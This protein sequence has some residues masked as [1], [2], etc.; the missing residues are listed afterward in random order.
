MPKSERQKLKLLYLRDYLC[1]NTDE[2]H[3]ASVQKLIDYLAAQDI[4]AERKSIYDDIRNLNDYGIEVLH[5][6]GRNGGYYVAQRDFELHELKLL[7]DAV[8]S[9]RFLSSK[10][11][12]LLI[13]K[14][15]A[16]SSSH[17]S[18][19]LRRELVL[20]GRLKT[21]NDD[22]F[23]SVDLLHDAIGRDSQIT[24]RY[25]DWGVDLQKHFRDK[26]YTASP[27]ALLWDDENYYLIAHSEKHGLTHFRVDKMEQICLTGKHR[28]FTDESRQFDPASYSK[29]VFGMY[30]GERSRVKL[31]FEN[32]LAG[33]VVDRFGRDIMLIPDGKDYFTMTTTVSISP[34]F[35]GWIAG[36]GGRAAIVF[37]KSAVEE[38]R[39]LCQSAINALPEG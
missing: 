33:V 12:G 5:K 38:Y 3:P 2:M 23:A 27:Y 20:S 35:M 15:A 28:I 29:E 19:L 32:S 13:K 22:A 39:K 26:T 11:S 8:L 36:F 14:L 34:N 4:R 16:L 10:Q 24:F 1:K 21:A 17:E 30:R 37:P 6:G 25:F 7:V 18:E 9:S 31:R